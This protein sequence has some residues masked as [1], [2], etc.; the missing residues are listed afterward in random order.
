MD[1]IFIMDLKE[2]QAEWG[3]RLGKKWIALLQRQMVLFLIVK[4]LKNEYGWCLNMD[5]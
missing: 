2:V 5:D 1:K 3:K 4:K